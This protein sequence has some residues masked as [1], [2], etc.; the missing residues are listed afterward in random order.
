MFKRMWS[1]ML[2]LTMVLAGC[3]QEAITA[4]NIVTKIREGQAN[5]NDVHAVM[6]VDY[7]SDQATGFIKAEVWS[8][9]TGN[10]DADGNEIK[11]F[12]AKI[13]DANDANMVGVE[14]VSDGTQGWLY[15]PAENKVYVGTAA[16]LSQSQMGQPDQEQGQGGRGR[17]DQTAMLGQLQSV[18]E[19][20]LDALTITILGEEKVA[21]FDTYKVSIAPKA[22]TQQQLPIDLLVDINVWLE[23]SNWMPVKFVLDAKDMGNVSFAAETLEVNKGIDKAVFSAQPPAGAEVVKIADM[24]KEMEQAAPTTDLTL[25][26]AKTQAGFSLLAPS[27]TLGTNLS[28]VQLLKLAKATTVIQTY[29]GADLEWTL[30]QAKG[31]DPDAKIERGGTQVTVRGVQ[32]TLIEGRGNVGVVLTWQEADVTFVITGNID[33]EQATKI[34]ESLK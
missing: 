27:E 3:G 32:G 20:G 7:S 15:E 14:V 11:A 33:G 6:R 34:A 25:D 28:D 24:I 9:K 16:E 23:D 2:A 31:D 26:Q 19:K 18:V 22:D 21:G 30:V 4:E 13:L 29:A 17:M 8:S 5:T 10:K 12:R 1:L